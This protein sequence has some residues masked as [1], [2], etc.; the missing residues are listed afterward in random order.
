MKKV[1]VFVES[2]AE[3]DFLQRILP[4]EELKDAEIVAATGIS[5]LARSVLVRRQKPVVVVMQAHS[6]D[7]DVIEERRGGKEELIQAAGGSI[8]VKVIAIVPEIE[9]WFFA[10][11]EAIAR[12]LGEPVTNDM[13]FLGKR[14][15]MGVLQLLAEKSKTKWDT[16]QAIGLLKAED[17]DRIRALPEVSELSTFLQRVQMDGKAA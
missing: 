17:I 9:A 11:P 2:S 15:P 16:R 8:P 3:A 6:T 13:M 7:P 5:S 12:I 4:P 1:Y 14:D 10:A